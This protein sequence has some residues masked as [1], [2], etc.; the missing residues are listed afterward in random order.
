MVFESDLERYEKIVSERN[1]K[2]SICQLVEMA[3]L[4]R[5]YPE[6]QTIVSILQRI[7]VMSPVKLL[8]EFARILHSVRLTKLFASIQNRIDDLKTFYEE[9][10]K[11]QF[12]TVLWNK[13]MVMGM[14]FA[15]EL[16][17]TRLDVVHRYAISIGSY[18]QGDVTIFNLVE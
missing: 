7:V 4:I 2:V 12:N 18:V 15:L 1:H 6:N 9:L 17:R 3:H 10:D 14:Y 5:L 16:T 8:E 13:I 11:E